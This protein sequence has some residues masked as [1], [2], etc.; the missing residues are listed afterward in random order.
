MLRSLI[1]FSLRFR[2]V[3]VG[4]SCL[5]LGY[6]VYV[7]L[8]S[9]YDVYPEFAP[10]RVEVQ[11]EAPGLSPEEVE[12]LVTRPIENALNGAPGLDTMRSQS[13]QGLS[14]I[15]LIFRDRVDIYRARQMV[16]ERLSQAAARLPAGV[17]PPNLAPLTGSTSLMLI[18]GL[19]SQQR[20]L[21]A[22]RTFADWV[23]RPRL[24]GV[25][26]VARVTV[27][28]GD[29]RQIQI[30]VVPEKLAHYDSSIEEVLASARQ[31]TGLRGAGFVE[32]ANQRIVLQSTSQ[33]VNAAGIGAA[34]LRSR[35]G[36]TVMLR[37]VAHVE[38]APAPAIG[39]ATVNGQPGVLVEVS[40]QFGENTIEVT[41]GV[42]KELTAMRPAIAAA[43]IQMNP[44]LFRPANFIDIAIR[45]LSTS[46]LLGGVFVG[47]VLF[48]FLFNLRIAFISLTAI[49]LSL[50]VSIIVLYY[51]GES[52]NTLTLGGLAIAIG[53]VVDDAIIDVENINRRLR[54]SREQLNFQTVFRIIQSASLEV[55]SAVVYATFVVAAVFIPVVALSGVQGRLFRPLGFTYV[56]A[57]LSSLVVALTITPA[58]C[59]ML[60]PKA[61]AKKEPRSLAWLKLHYLRV[62]EFTIA[63]RGLLWAGALLVSVAA[64]ATLPFFGGAFLPDLHEGHFIV[65]TASLPGTALSETTRLGRNI[66]N[67][68]L[69]IPTVDSVAQQIGRAALADDTAG[70]NY[71]EFHV[72]LKPSQGSDGTRIE[73]QIRATSSRFPGLAVSIKPFLTERMEEILSGSPGAVVVKVF[74]DNLDTLDQKAREVSAAIASV[75]GAADVQISSPPGIPEVAIRLRPERLAQFGFQPVAVL[76]I[77]QTAYQG[78]PVS[79]VYEGNRITDVTVILDPAVRD[80]PERIG[81]LQLESLSGLRVKL[82]DLA[83]IFMTNGRSLISHDGA[84]RLQV[85]T[86]NVRGRDPASFV[87]EAEHIVSQKISFPS[88]TYALFSG[89]A[90]A[91]TNAQHEIILYSVV[92]IVGIILLLYV[93]YGNIRNLALTL[94]NLPFALVGGVVAAFLTGGYL[95]VGSLVG[96]ITL[97]GITM[98]NSIMMVSHFEHLV[99]KEGMSWGREAAF[100]GA[101]ER[102]VPILMTAL[103]TALG[104]LPLALGSEAPGREIEGPMAIVILGGLLT[105]TLLN[106]LLL[107]SLALRYGR[108]QARQAL[109]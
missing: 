33:S 100:R 104:L 92:A 102:L 105:S 32:T 18:V 72:K 73:D 45:N 90:E 13:I 56:V 52:L 106:L 29:I 66:S 55:R 69:K 87:S 53:E 35:N 80:D 31:A 84:S 28:G 68:L 81:S 38:D 101:S 93:V 60:L 44:A 1:S 82:D 75:R 99:T 48:L 39:G 94:A 78:T 11:T 4:L 98:R 22:L 34:I 74:G 97:F 16:S 40:S 21:M 20:S 96:F 61:A 59:F 10:P 27:F 9:K 8:H 107:P 47:I 36:A 77:L 54:E 85:V 24:L 83:D 103:V 30:Q 88:G 86:C 91:S 65:H 63:W 95:T 49:P 42:E 19:T 25:P 79:Q 12:A 71:S 17:E 2:G 43:N 26:G 108:F 70:T 14:V 58:L 57:I 46:L 23:L 109:E 5:V 76:D 15:T 62:L 37:D 67:E 50:L 3:I 7:T 64:A 89:T 6:G 51:A 41:N